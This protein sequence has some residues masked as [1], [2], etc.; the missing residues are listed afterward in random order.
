MMET[1]KS[2]LVKELSLAQ[3]LAEEKIEQQIEEL[4]H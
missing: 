2:L 1:A 3:D 4:F